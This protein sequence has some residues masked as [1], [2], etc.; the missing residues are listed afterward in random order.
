MAKTTPNLVDLYIAEFPANVQQQLQKL[1]KIILE[2]VPN[3]E[4]I[5]SYKMPAYKV[6]ECLVYFA[7]YKNHVGFYPTGS[8]IAAFEHELGGYKYSKGAVQFEMEKELPR[9]LIIRMVQYRLASAIVKHESKKVLKT[10][11]NGHQFYKSSDCK[12]CPICE[13]ANKPNDGFM[14]NISAPARRALI[15][16]NINSLTNLAQYTEKEILDLHGIGPTAI[17]KLKAALKD[18]GLSFRKI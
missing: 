18:A 1:R 10:C 9:D 2:T 17:P 12:S 16:K 5:I 8:G 14:A 7:G 11:K 13:T 3:A 6:H 15:S 4:E